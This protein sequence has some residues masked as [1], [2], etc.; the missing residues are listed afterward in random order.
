MRARLCASVGVFLSNHTELNMV[1]TAS[2][3]GPLF[4]TDLR[5]VIISPFPSLDFSSTSSYTQHHILFFFFFGK[6]IGR[7]KNLA[8]LLFNDI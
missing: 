8:L 6:E 5:A 1:T 7:N 2:A 4:W 3:E